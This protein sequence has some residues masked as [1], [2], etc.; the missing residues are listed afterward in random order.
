MRLKGGGNR[1]RGGD[2]KSGCVHLDFYAGSSAGHN[3]VGGGLSVRLRSGKANSNSQPPPWPTAMKMCYFTLF[4]FIYGVLTSIPVMLDW[5]VCHLN[6]CPPSIHLSPSARPLARS[7]FSFPILRALPPR[8][9]LSRTCPARPPA[10]ARGPHVLISLP[11]PR[12]SSIP[13][14]PLSILLLLSECRTIAPRFSA[15]AVFCG[16]HH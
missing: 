6:C 9:S 15:V 16:I 3:F 10:P 2:A 1:E 12:L 13:P 4:Y 11:F 7:Q 14:L 5:L 8:C